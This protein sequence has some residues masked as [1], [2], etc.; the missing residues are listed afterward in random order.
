[1][2]NHIHLLVSAK[3]GNLSDILRDF[4]K[5]TAKQII[6]AIRSNEQESRREWMLRIFQQAEEANS[7]NGS[8]Q[9]WR[10]DNQPK[11]CFSPAFTVQKM[12]Y[13]HNNPVAAGL[14]EKPEDYLYSSA[15]A[16]LTNE[17][18]SLLPVVCL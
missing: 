4:K 16:Y 14:V 12:D 2:S 10:Q 3:E 8:Y 1:M 18:S 17:R 13:I 11:V 5:F 9:L 15:R 6:A 7:R